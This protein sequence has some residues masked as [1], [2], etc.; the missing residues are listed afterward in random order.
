MGKMSRPEKPESWRK[1]FI[2]I[3]LPLKIRQGTG[4]PLRAVA[5]LDE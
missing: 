4:S 3:A 5:L 2:F 1:R